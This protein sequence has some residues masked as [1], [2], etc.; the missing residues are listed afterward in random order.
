MCG[1]GDDWEG[2]SQIIWLIPDWLKGERKTTLDM[3]AVIHT[4][5]NETPT[6][7]KKSNK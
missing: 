5:A 4:G 6:E 3:Q 7:L 1:S 2:F